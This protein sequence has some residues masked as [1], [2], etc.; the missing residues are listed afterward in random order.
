M[1]RYA[2][3]VLAMLAFLAAV[4]AAEAHDS[5]PWKRAMVGY[6]KAQEM[7]P[8]PP[9]VV[10]SKRWGGQAWRMARRIETWNR[11]HTHTVVVF[12]GNSLT[13]HEYPKLCMDQLVG[14][15]EWYNIAV[16]GQG[17]NEMMRRAL[18]AADPRAADAT[19]AIYIGW[20]GTNGLMSQANGAVFYEI[21]A[22]HFRARRAAGFETITLDTL[23]ANRA[24][25]SDA[26][27]AVRSRFNGLMASGWQTFA[28]GFASVASDPVIGRQEA[29]F[30]ALLYPDGLHLSAAGYQ[31]VAD[32]VAKAIR[33]LPDPPSGELDR[34]LRRILRPHLH[35]GAHR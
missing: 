27:D 19:R 12:D 5:R 18:W 22:G 34:E 20:E 26:W 11:N 10:K 14:D 33:N 17:V 32:K 30:D 9:L 15:Y 2:V 3:I 24:Q 28:D 29:T 16:S 8:L 13:T 1:R 6:W 21:W 35:Q 25:R 4:P 31:I 23:P 7:G